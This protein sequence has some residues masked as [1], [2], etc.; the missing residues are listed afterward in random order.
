M[1]IGITG[2]PGTGKSSVAKVLATMLGFERI[3]CTTFVKMHKLGTKKGKEIEVPIPRLKKALDKELKMHKNVV[4][5]GHLLCEMPLALDMIFV[6]RCAP[7]ILVKRLGK[8]KYS[9]KKIHE[10]LECELLDYCTIK[11]EA[12]YRNVRELSSEKRGVRACATILMQAV[13]DKKK[14]LDSVDYSHEFKWFEGW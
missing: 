5:E 1:K 13:K 3:E 2:T 10:N 11:S 12:N 6:I 14:K 4:V 9:K 8:R 7:T